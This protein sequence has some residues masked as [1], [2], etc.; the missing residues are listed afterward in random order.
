MEVFYGPT[1]LAVADLQGTETRLPGSTRLCG[2]S[3]GPTTMAD[4]QDHKEERPSTK[5][6][7]KA[8]AKLNDFCN[9]VFVMF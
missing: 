8:S 1:T 6:E 4:T 3:Y 5:E 9:L 7:G 2:I